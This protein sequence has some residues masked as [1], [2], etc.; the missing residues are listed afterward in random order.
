MVVSLWP[1]YLDVGR[2]HVKMPNCPEISKKQ[3]N[4]GD[5]GPHLHF[6]EFD[7][8]AG[9]QAGLQGYHQSFVRYVIGVLAMIRSGELDA[10]SRQLWFIR[11]R[12]HYSW[13]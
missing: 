5:K 2:V 12:I 8:E 9:V 10:A 7:Q 11:I 4:L 6:V 1:T 13:P 3:L